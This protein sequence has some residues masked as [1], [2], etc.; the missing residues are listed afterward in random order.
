MWGRN[1]AQL[2]RVS[3]CTQVWAATRGPHMPVPVHCIH[4]C[5]QASGM[6]CRKACPYLKD[7][8]VPPRAHEQGQQGVPQPALRLP[9][10]LGTGAAHRSSASGKGTAHR[11]SWV[12]LGGAAGCPG[13][14]LD[15]VTPRSV[16]IARGRGTDSGGGCA[17]EGLPS[18]RL[19]S[20]S[21]V[22][23]TGQMQTLTGESGAAAKRAAPRRG[24][25]AAPSRRCTVPG[26]CGGPGQ[27]TEQLRPHRELHHRCQQH[28][29]SGPS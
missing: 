12:K 10:L 22:W 13:R 27:P 6:C 19:R 5:S 23:G 26:A 29:W 3:T 2:A 21:S 14:G 28:R 9:L 20:S 1:A 4:E 16:R 8:G 7:P 24:R 25:R 11:R 17:A 15:T 18:Q